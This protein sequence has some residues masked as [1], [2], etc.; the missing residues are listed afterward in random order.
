MTNYRRA[1]VPGAMYFFAVNLVDRRSTLLIERIDALRTAVRYTQQR[2]PFV[3]TAMT[4]LPDHMHAVWT[5]PADDADFPLRWRLVKTFFSRQIPHGE[6]RRASRIA[7][8]ERGIWQRRYWEHLIRDEDDLR[9]CVDYTHFN[10]VKHGTLG[11]CRIG[12]TPRF[13]AKCAKDGGLAIGRRLL[14]AM[15]RSASGGD[16]FRERNPSDGLRAGERRQGGASST[17]SSTSSRY[18]AWRSNSSA[19][20]S[21]AMRNSTSCSSPRDPASCDSNNS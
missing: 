4:I 7:K 19:S 8:G 17:E 12:L 13:T 9:R 14:K 16:G 20:A 11:A 1:H 10:Q 3:I 6:Y 5:L 18:C 15:R 21:G 2:H